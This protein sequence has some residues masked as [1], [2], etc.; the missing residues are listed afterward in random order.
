MTRRTRDYTDQERAEAVAMGAVCGPLKAAK[1]LG[2]PPRTLSGWMRRPAS[3]EAR[4]EAERVIAQRLADAHE[5]ALGRLHVALQAKDARL[6]DIARAVE[7]LGQQRALAEGRATGN[8]N[9]LLGGTAG[10]GADGQG[11]DRASAILSAVFQ[12]PPDDLVWLV[13]QLMLP[14]Q[15]AV[16]MTDEQ[17]HAWSDLLN[18]AISAQELAIAAAGIEEANH[19]AVLE[20]ATTVER[21]LAQ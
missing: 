9:V 15:K 8:L 1:A 18:A 3:N 19:E 2:I 4:A 12:L 10:R 21:L 5:L 17:I 6:G 11:Q 16:G 13:D 7:V 14:Y 20:L